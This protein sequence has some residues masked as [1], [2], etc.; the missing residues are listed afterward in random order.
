MSRAGL[1]GEE[2]L[3]R[4]TESRKDFDRAVA[5]EVLA[6]SPDR[7]TPDCAL[8]GTCG[9]CQLQ[10][11]AY[12]AQARIK[13]GWVAQ[14]VSRAGVGKDLVRP[15]VPSPQEYGYRFRA[16]LKVDP[17]GLTGFNRAGSNDVVPLED[18]PIMSPELNS[19][20]RRLSAFLATTR[21]GVSFELEAGALG[22]N[23]F[24]LVRPLSGVKGGAKGDFHRLRKLTQKLR[25]HFP[26]TGLGI[27]FNRPGLKGDPD[28]PPPGSLVLPLEGL[29]MTLFPGV[30]AQAQTAQNRALVKTVAEL[31]GIRPGTK[32]LDLMAGMG[33]LS[34]P[35]AKAGAEVRAV[36]LDPLA[37]INGRY[38]AAQAGL[39]A[40]FLNLSAKEA[41]KELSSSAPGVRPGVVV[42]DPPRA[43]IKGLAGLLVQAAPKRLVYISCNPPALARDL[44]ELI[45]G[46]YQVRELA[47]LDL[48][49]QTFHL[50]TVCLLVKT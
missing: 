17:Q 34:L 4:L 2:V 48:F 15:L 41:L 31:A 24:A 14:L 26:G 23:G 39:E 44:G 7:A 13:H 29:D 21:P 38:N 19:L 18:C 37:C 35:L 32:A 28:G 40:E 10:H 42:A 47:P 30:F 11:L 22:G 20:A 9:G 33:N 12:P 43:G 50:E 5:E 46:G 8:F 16:R 25:E 49:P 45:R 27:Y 36:E 3:A 6:P 1:P